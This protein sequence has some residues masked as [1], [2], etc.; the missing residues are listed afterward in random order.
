MLVVML[1][2]N[3][4]LRTFA[5]SISQLIASNREG[6]LSSRDPV[7]LN[8]NYM[9]HTHC[10][11]IQVHQVKDKYPVQQFVLHVQMLA[12]PVQASVCRL[13][14]GKSDT[15][16]TTKVA[17]VDCNSCRAD[18]K[19]HPGWRPPIRSTLQQ[20]NLHGRHVFASLQRL[21]KVRNLNSTAC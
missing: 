18:N 3:I 15:E 1:P 5:V 16:R 7:N 19:L 12:A 13:K 4:L 14:D 21:W 20:L 6:E 9:L 17:M 11:Y 8:V 10:G 2:L